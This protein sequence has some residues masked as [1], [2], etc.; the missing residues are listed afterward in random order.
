MSKKLYEES[1][2]Q[3]IADAIRNKLS[4]TKAFLVS[5]MSG[6]IDSIITPI[7]Q[8]KSITENGSFIPDEGF[9][10][11]SQVFVNVP[12]VANLIHKTITKNGRYYA[13]SDNADGY[14]YIDVNSV[15]NL[16]TKTVHYNQIVYPD[17]DYDGLEKVIVEIDGGAQRCPRA[18]IETIYRNAASDLSWDC[19]AS[20]DA[21]T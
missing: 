7:L 1:N 2:I 9:N 15:P 12:V 14:D 19:I 5:E 11:L 20:I 6:A 18:E 3:N 21:M 10:G 17:N 16:Q 4:S 13:S 8:T